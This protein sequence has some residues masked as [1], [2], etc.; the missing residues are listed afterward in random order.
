MLNVYIRKELFQLKYIIFNNKKLKKIK[1]NQSHEREV[2]IT[3]AEINKIGNKKKI[4]K[5]SKTKSWFFSD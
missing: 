1:I 5:V 2:K 4:E 3:I